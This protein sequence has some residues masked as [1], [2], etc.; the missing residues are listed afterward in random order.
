MPKS[1][2][3]VY[4]ATMHSGVKP[5]RLEVIN[6]Y[7]YSEFYRDTDT[8]KHIWSTPQPLSCIGDGESFFLGDYYMTYEEAKT[9]YI[10]ERRDKILKLEEE[11]AQVETPNE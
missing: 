2:L 1:I 9:A 4:Y 10:K 11:I 6:G 5:I 3:T 8:I 7:I